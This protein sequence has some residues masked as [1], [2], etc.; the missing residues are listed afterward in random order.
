MSTCI[1]LAPVSSVR[2]SLRFTI[3]LFAAGCSSSFLSAGENWPNHCYN[4]VRRVPCHVCLLR[5]QICVHIGQQKP[6]VGCLSQTFNFYKSH[7]AIR[8]EMNVAATHSA[9]GAY[10]PRHRQPPAPFVIVV[11][12]HHTCMGH[13]VYTC[14]RCEGRYNDKSRCRLHLKYFQLLIRNPY[15]C[16]ESK[17]GQCVR[18][19]SWGAR[20][21]S[22]L[23]FEASEAPWVQVDLVRGRDTV[24]EVLMITATITH[25]LTRKTFLTSYLWRKFHI[26]INIAQVK[27]RL[28]YVVCDRSVIMQNYVCSQVEDMC[29]IV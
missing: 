5:Q 17:W 22:K 18:R 12:G 21:N 6:V 14:R 8:M 27:I 10:M 28:F 29:G 20:E 25:S 2:W 16:G 19:T 9:R 26:T 23:V 4:T 15:E 11:R 1:H 13:N 24:W 7:F 3:L